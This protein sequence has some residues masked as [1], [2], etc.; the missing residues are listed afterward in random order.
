MAASKPAIY[1][2]MYSWPLGCPARGVEAVNI[3]AAGAI[4]LVKDEYMSCTV[5][6]NA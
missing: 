4:S 1:L 6:L 3:A 5:R 2:T